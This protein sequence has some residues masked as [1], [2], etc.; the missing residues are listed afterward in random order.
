MTTSELTYVIEDD[1]ITATIT[2]TLLEKKLGGGRVQTYA[3]GQRALDQLTSVLREGANDVPDLILLD[4]NMPMMDG[5]EFLDAVSSL[6]LA[7][8]VCIVVL[9]SSIN[10][11]DRIKAA[12][13]H[14]VAGYFSKPLDAGAVIRMLHLRRKASG[15]GP[16]ESPG[17]ETPL[18]HVVYQSRT[19]TALDDAELAQLLTQSRAYNAAH[20]LTG[21]LLYSHGNIVQLLEG[22]QAKVDA[23]FS[24]IARDPRH[25]R[26]IRLAD[27]PIPHRLFAQ[28]SMGFRTINPA[29]FAH[30]TGYIDPDKTDC[31][32]NNPVSTDSDLHM[33]LATFV[34]GDSTFSADVY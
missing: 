20:G 19:T 10:A 2:R 32:T 6:P 17:P 3:N 25:F 31:L 33:L 24:R 15:P 27:G 34:S 11:E 7:Q 9:T 16:G 14:N 13:Y 28:W 26:V 18:H 8:P 5:W 1:S 22:T 30:L 12:S 23:V 21:V 29:D 4:L